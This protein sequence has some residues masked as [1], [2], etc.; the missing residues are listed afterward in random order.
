MLARDFGVQPG[1]SEGSKR[2]ILARGGEERRGGVQGLS[3]RRPSN[4][5]MARD[6][7]R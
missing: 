4:A 5:F 3:R 7:L 6:Q 2:V 1:G